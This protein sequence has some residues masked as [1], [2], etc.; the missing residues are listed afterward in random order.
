MNDTITLEQV[1]DQYEYVVQINDDKH[2]LAD[3]S[4]TVLLE[5]ASWE[6]CIDKLVEIL[7]DVEVSH[8]VIANAVY[9]RTGDWDAQST[10]A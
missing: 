9:F 3:R 1:I 8:V 10:L 4:D 2:R 7:G 5:N 6:Q